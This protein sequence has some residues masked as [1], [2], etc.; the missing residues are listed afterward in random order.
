MFNMINIETFVKI[1]FRTKLINTNILLLIGW[2]V[3]HYYRYFRN[4]IF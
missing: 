1:N 3:L 4:E 2:K